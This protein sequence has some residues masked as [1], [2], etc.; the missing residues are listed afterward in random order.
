V[1]ALQNHREA[2]I[3]SGLRAGW[4]YFLPLLA[5]RF[6]LA[7]PLVVA[8]TLAAHSILP[9]LSSLF[10][11]P[12][13]ERLFTFGQTGQFAGIG[14]LILVISLLIAALDI[15]AERAVVLDGSPIGLALRQ[16]W[17]MLWHH[18]PDY[19][20]IGM[21]FLGLGVLVALTF[22]LLLIPVFFL[23][24]LASLGHAIEEVNVFTFTTSALGPLTIVA[25]LLGFGLSTLVTVFTASVWT[26]AYREWQDKGRLRAT[27]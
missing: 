13:G 27:A 15:G 1:G 22:A 19:L 4:Q 5:V 8:G 12:T 6:L 17:L 24:S 18:L 11:E 7:L 3:K 16:G 23:A 9:A 21:V 2:T 26:I 25:L 14:S 20:A 10:T